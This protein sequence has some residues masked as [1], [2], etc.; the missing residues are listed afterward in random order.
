[1]LFTRALLAVTATFI[2]SS[3]AY[4]GFPDNLTER[5]GVYQAPGP[6]DSRGP[7]PGL[8]TL[9]NHGLINR[10]G[11][12]IYSQD[13]MTAFPQ[14]FGINVNG[15][16][17]AL[18]NFEVVCEYAKGLTCGTPANDGT[19]ILTNLTILGEPHAFEHDHSFSRQDYK[20]NYVSC[21]PDPVISSNYLPLTKCAGPWC[22]Y[23]QHLLQWNRIP[24]RIERHRRMCSALPDRPVQAS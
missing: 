13:I 8:N 12:Y 3:A 15:F 7:C 18:H 20:E 6:N 2:A 10:N 5:L 14:G 22:C 23:G 17:Q 1:M 21:P 4:D 16:F 24:E 19:F 11:S 9:A